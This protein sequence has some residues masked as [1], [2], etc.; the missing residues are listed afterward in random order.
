MDEG[1]NLV[2][3]PGMTQ[4]SEQ[5]FGAAKAAADKSMPGCADV[6]AGQTCMFFAA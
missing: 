2:R 4:Q 5:A 6:T 1:Q 3:Q